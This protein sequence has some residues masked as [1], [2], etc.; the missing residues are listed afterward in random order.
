[1]RS[2]EV[3]VAAEAEGEAAVAA[4]DRWVGEADDQWVADM[5]EAL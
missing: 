5:V 1:M 2:P 4:V 3:G